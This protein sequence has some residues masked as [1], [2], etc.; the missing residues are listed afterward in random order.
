MIKF[1]RK[2]RQNLLESLPAEQAGNKIGSYLTY[3]IGEI[4]LVVIGIL[5]ALSINTWNE[6]RKE[7]SIVKNLLKNIRYDLV[8]DTVKFSSDIKRIPVIFGDAKFLLNSSALDTLSANSLFDRLP[9]TTFIYRVK[10]QSYQKVI[11]AGITDFFEFNDLFDD[12]NTYFTVQSDLYNN[13]TKWD[14]DDTIN[15][16]KQWFARGFEIDIF[17]GTLYKENDIKFAHSEA[18]RKAIFI[19]QMNSSDLRNSIKMNMYRKMSLNQSL[20]NMKESAKAIILKINEQ[21]ED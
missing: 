19:E 4:V 21:L 18:T 1:F 3:A 12:I 17:E 6:E 5:I 7:K 14:I 16:G 11:N 15:D 2:I 20:N 10:N 9:Y 8:A 13:A